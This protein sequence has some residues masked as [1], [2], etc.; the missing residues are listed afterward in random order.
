MATRLIEVKRLLYQIG[1]AQYYFSP[2]PGGPGYR[3]F[4][5]FYRERVVLPVQPA[6]PNLQRCLVSSNRSPSP[7][8]HGP[9]LLVGGIKRNIKRAM[10]QW[11]YRRLAC[12]ASCPGVVRRKYAADECDDREAVKPI[13]A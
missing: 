9:A 5:N 2:Q 8:G 12:P 6:G 4:I 1:C 10:I 11:I 13:I 7:L 3:D